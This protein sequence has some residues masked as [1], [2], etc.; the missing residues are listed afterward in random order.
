MPLE[1]GRKMYRYEIPVNEN[2]YSAREKYLNDKKRE[3]E[4]L[5]AKK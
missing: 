1:G 4:I 5:E 2:A 3:K